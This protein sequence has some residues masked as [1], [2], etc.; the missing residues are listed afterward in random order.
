[1]SPREAS[2]TAVINIIEQKKASHHVVAAML[3]DNNNWQPVERAFAKRLTEGT[4]ERLFLID[5]LLDRVSSTPVR[6][7]KPWIRSVLRC[8][9]Y[10]LIYM[11]A[12]P[13]SAACNEAVKLVK[14]RGF[15]SLGG[16]VNGV[17]RSIA[18]DGQNI[19]KEALTESGER[20]L[21]LKSST[22]EWLIRQWVRDYGQETAEMIAM[23][24]F[25][26]HPLTIRTNLSRNSTEELKER[27]RVRGINVKP[28]AY[29]NNALFISACEGLDG[30]EEFQEGLFQVQDESSILAGLS[31]ELRGDETVLDLC[32]APGGKCL[33]IAD[34]LRYLSGSRRAEDAPVAE[35]STT[36]RITA[37]DLTEGKCALIRENRDR[38]HFDNIVI[39]QADACIYDPAWEARADLVLA[40]LPCSGTGVI[41]RKPDIKYNMSEQQ[42][43]ELIKLQRE[44]LTQAVRYVKPGGKLLFSTCTLNQDENDGGRKYLI[45]LGMKP[46]SL[47][48]V[49]V[50]GLDTASIKD[51]YLQL[52]PGI[53]DCD[54]FYMALFQK[55]LSEETEGKN[56]RAKTN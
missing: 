32:A 18:R 16:F 51:G 36:G 17:L 34:R 12:V 45:R 7:I 19:L 33:H 30:L 22:P 39:E 29:C 6:K 13:A 31:M 48:S 21:S 8:G 14:K 15:Q 4:I 55:E 10:Q 38:C 37:R 9:V 40:D 42:Q 50:T 28:A 25:E 20:G 56:G 24:Q 41:G 54:G 35:K 26:D 44:I 27:L 47:F 5:F 46:I 2:A 1:M 49:P 43:E 53:H 52:I 3:R 23:A 11:D